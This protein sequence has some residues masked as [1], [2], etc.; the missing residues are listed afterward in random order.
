MAR[1]EFEARLM[2]NAPCTSLAPNIVKGTG[3]G[4][5]FGGSSK[6]KTKR[7]GNGNGN[8][9][10]KGKSS[11]TTTSRFQAQAQ[12]QSHARILQEQGV[13][14]IDHVLPPDLADVVREN[15]YTLREES[16]QLVAS[17]KVPSS[18]R[19]A[20]V[21]LK[22]HRRDLTLPLNDDWAAAAAAQL[23]L[24]SPV[25][26]VLES[27]LTSRAL[28]REWSCLISDPGSPR[29]V[30]H[31]DTPW[32]KEP[33]LYTCFVALQDVTVEMG[34][35][36]WLP[37][38]HTQAMHAQF[39]DETPPS[40]TT[41]HDGA[42]PTTTTT[43]RMIMSPKDELLS[44]QPSVLGTLSKGSCAIFDSRLLHCGGANVSIDK[45]RALLYC[46]FQ[47]PQ[48]VQVGNPGSIR[49]D[50]IGKWTLESLS[51]EL[52]LRQTTKSV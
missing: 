15:V 35:T 28:L 14:R 17:G 31:P 42:H 6:G 34:P 44:T 26:F 43:T 4:G 23:L 18:A 1:G 36:T 8:T 11:T 24:E 21:L 30:V 48:I 38:T 41:N 3:S 37:Q 52:R 10:S 49:S 51:N 39:Q 46:S 25:G 9:N 5:G 13:V 12:A 32:Q 2:E 27:L 29:Q 7:N 40:S 16:E 20:D 45:S 33:V 50:L 19:F 47:N 22:H